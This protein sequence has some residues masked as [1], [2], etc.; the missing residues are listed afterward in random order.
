MFGKF[1]MYVHTSARQIF[2]NIKLD[3]TSHLRNWVNDVLP[4]VTLFPTQSKTKCL[5]ITQ[6]YTLVFFD[7]QI[8]RIC[9]WGSKLESIK[10]A[11]SYTC[12]KKYFHDLLI[13]LYKLSQY[14]FLSTFNQKIPQHEDPIR[15]GNCSCLY[16]CK[17]CLHQSM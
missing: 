16:F 5:I 8:D 15:I 17:R 13:C 1:R 6:L 10:L 2:C 14:H 12:G 11:I 4:S 7:W 3:M 9:N